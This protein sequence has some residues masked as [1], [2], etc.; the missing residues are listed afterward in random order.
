[1]ATIGS[2]RGSRAVLA[3][4]GLLAAGVAAGA[5]VFGANQASSAPD[6]RIPV[7]ALSR[8][9]TAADTLPQQVLNAPT[10][11]RFTDPAAAR[12]VYSEA[13]RRVFLVPGQGGALCQ[14]LALGSGTN[15]TVVTGCPSFPEVGDAL[16]V[17]TYQPTE[18]SNVTA[19]AVVPDG[20]ATVTAE[21]RSAAINSNAIVVDVSANTRAI[22]ISGAAGDATLDLPKGPP[23]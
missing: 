21:G 6:E 4:L 9:A 5:A 13:G 11:K 14:V 18:D 19:V 7:A 15:L 16:P 12:L 17:M 23:R 1:M 20:F 3:G 8:P 10:V 22:S 2:T